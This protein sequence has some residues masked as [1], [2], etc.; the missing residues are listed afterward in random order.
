MNLWTDRHATML[1]RTIMIG[2]VTSSFALA[3]L[4]S[5]CTPP[6][7]DDY[8]AET[9]VAA[10]RASEGARA[11]TASPT[12]ASLTTTTEAEVTEGTV[13]EGTVTEGAATEAADTSAARSAARG[14]TVMAAEDAT[15]GAH[16]VDGEGR[17]LYLFT[18]D[19][20]NKSTCTGTCA[21]TWPPALTDATPL[22]GVGVDA[23]LLG[24]ALRDD[25]TA[26]V[27]YNGHPLY[28]FSADVA[29]GEAR[30]QGTR[31]VWYVVSP[32]GDKV[33]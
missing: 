19:T 29:A 20:P 23:A 32:T 10:A 6:A 22:P 12:T 3:G 25:G 13:A 27:T 15:H 1:G 21:E 31:G 5:A 2:A 7:I 33:E 11:T 28:R 16:L 18:S 9:P 14:L 26:Q 17:A 8:P 30:G 24:I 4:L